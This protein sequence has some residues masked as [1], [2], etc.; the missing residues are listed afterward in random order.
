MIKLLKNLR[1]KEWLMLVLCLGLIVVQV[2]LDLTMPDYMTEITQLVQTEGSSL[3]SVWLAGGKMLLCALCSLVTAIVVCF[4]ASKVASTLSYRIRTQVY[5]KVTSFSAEEMKRFSTASLITRTTNDITQVQMVYS[6]AIQLL[7]KA[8]IMAVWAIIKIAGKGWQWSVATACAVGILIVMLSIVIIFAVPRFK[9]I[10]KLTDKLNSATRENLTGVRVVRAYNAESYQEDKFDKVNSELT[11]NHLFTS[12]VMAIMQPGMTLISN[13]L[14]L[15]IYWI[16][17]F[18]IH[19]ADNMAKLT[20]FSNMIVYIQYAM[21]IVM[22]FMMLVMMFMM[23]PRAS[24]SAKRINEILDTQPCV[25]DGDKI[26]PQNRDGIVEFRNV[27]FKYPDAEDYVIKDVTFSANKGETIAFIG[28]TGS[29]KSTL[30]NL[31]PRFYDVT[32]GEILIDGMNVKD[33]TQK[34]LHNRIGYVSQKAVLFSGT[35]E[36]NLKFGDNGQ[37][38]LSIEDMDEAVEIAQAKNFIYKLDDCYQHHVAQ[39]GTNYSGGQKQRLS[40]ARAIA[41][42]P[43]IYIFDDSFSALDYKTDK[44]LRKALKKKSKDATTFIVAQRIGTIKDADKIVVLEDGNVVGM[45]KHKELLKS[46]QVYREIALSQ[47]SKEELE[48]A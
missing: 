4:I 46:C 7:F 42:N 2:W 14:T 24:V 21:M 28:S 43:E 23:L 5:D 26:A 35:I 8:P 10:Q 11:A 18:L 41:R 9:R 45:G 32:S 38:E 33:Y 31:I 22:S 44:A 16:G 27:S 39:G 37:S 13:G 34:E 1:L 3:S 6:M 30:I 40:I 25:V 48:N 20:Y 17:A 36:S 15:A 12:R 47:L 19:S 29:G